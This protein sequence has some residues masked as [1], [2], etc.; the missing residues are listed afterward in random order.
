MISGFLFI[1]MHS[2]NGQRIG[3]AR[4]VL[5]TVGEAHLIQLTSEGEKHSEP[6][7]RVPS[8]LADPEK[9]GKI[10]KFVLSKVY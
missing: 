8:C 1:L 2:Y 3:E 9:F 6:A 4:E 5:R 10:N 7:M